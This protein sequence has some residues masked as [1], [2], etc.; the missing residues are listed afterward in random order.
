[1][2]QRKAKEYRQ[3]MRQYDGVARDVDDLKRRVGVLEVYNKRERREAAFDRRCLKELNQEKLR[4]HKELGKQ[5]KTLKYELLAV[6]VLVCL[7]CALVV[8]NGMKAEHIPDLVPDGHQGV[9]GGHGVLEHIRA[10]TT[11]DA[12]SNAVVL[13]G[14]AGNEAAMLASGYYSEAVPMPYEYQGYM[15]EYCRLY[16]CPYPL[17]LA[18]AE[19]E[20]SFRMDAVG[21]VGEVGI[22]QLNPGPSGTYH[23]ALRQ[24]TGLDPTTPEGNIAGGCCLLGK[25]LAEYEDTA[26]AAMAYSMGHAGAEKARAAGTTSTRYTDTVLAAEARWECVVNPWDGE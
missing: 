1:M 11:D 12:A 4:R 8:V 3:A 23:D 18:V 24:E 21:D 14:S 10:D 15:R 22:M 2:S 26:M 20:S 25:Y 6:A 19:T 9:L 5:T 7:M 16:G 17:A 13:Q